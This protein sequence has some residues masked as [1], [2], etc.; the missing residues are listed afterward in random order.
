LF[1]TDKVGNYRLCVN[2][3]KL[4]IAAD[5]D[6]FLRAEILGI[7]GTKLGEMQYFMRTGGLSTTS[8]ELS[9]LECIVIVSNLYPYSGIS[10]LWMSKYSTYFKKNQR[11]VQFA[12]KVKVFVPSFLRSRLKNIFLNILRRRI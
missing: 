1:N 4:L 3:T 2:G 5:Y 7:R 8:L 12:E 10:Q 6:W 9:I 11:S